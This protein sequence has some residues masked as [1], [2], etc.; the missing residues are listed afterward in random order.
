MFARVARPGVAAESG[1]GIGLALARRLA[2]M[3][4]GTLGVVSAGEG[5]GATFTLRIPALFAAASE[6]AT[7]VSA[8][9]ASSGGALDIVVV[10]DNDDIADVLAEWL[11][12]LGHAV[13]VARTGKR[14]VELVREQPPDLVICDLGLPDVDGM[15]VCRQVRR[16]PLE[17]QPVM[18]ALTGWGREGDVRSTREAGFEHHLVKPVATDR[19]QT[20]LAKIGEARRSSQPPPSGKHSD[21]QRLLS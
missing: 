8:P 15:E 9:L 14:G 10:E 20:L 17:H 12:E 19:L 7:P 16:L 4:G 11:G 13:R 21:Q 6:V 18:V 5:R 3:H 2:E 1:L